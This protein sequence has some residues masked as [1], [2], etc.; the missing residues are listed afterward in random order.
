MIGEMF[1]M[2]S[3]KT[4]KKLQII[5]DC[6]PADRNAALYAAG[7]SKQFL[8]LIQVDGEINLV[9]MRISYLID[10]W[11]AGLQEKF[12]KNI[13][14]SILFKPVEPQSNS[15][16]CPVLKVWVWEEAAFIIGVWGK[17][18]LSQL[19]SIEKDIQDSFSSEKDNT[20]I[21]IQITG[22]TEAEYEGPDMTCPGYY[23]YEEISRKVEEIPF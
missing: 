8:G 22:Y 10:G 14:H 9:I 6:S 21:M 19:A 1:K 15:D 2:L 11:E 16:K 12:E 23:E 17:C 7:L 18:S 3:D 5:L 4:I 20:E 13:Q